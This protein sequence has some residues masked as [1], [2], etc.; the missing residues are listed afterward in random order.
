MITTVTNDFCLEMRGL[1]T[2]TKPIGSNCVNG[3]VE[4]RI[5][6]GSIFLEMDTSKVY[7][8]KIVKNGNDE[9]VGTWLEL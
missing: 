4:G 3:N 8:L 6:N 9:Y 2:D 1:S 5:S 7:I